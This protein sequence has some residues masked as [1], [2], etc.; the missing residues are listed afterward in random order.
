MVSKE[1]INGYKRK[2]IWQICGGLFLA[3][4]IPVSIGDLIDSINGVGENDV[5]TSAIVLAI[6]VC[7]PIMC[8][9]FAYK[10]KEKIDLAN[11]NQ[12]V[13]SNVKDE[14][15]GN[16]ITQNKY[17]DGFSLMMAEEKEKKEEKTENE[18]EE[19]LEKEEIDIFDI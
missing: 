11:S 17:E 1:K 8:F 3:L 13:S 7:L 5:V 2:M 15:D 19:Q 9:R 6:F 10:N 16:D 4:C 14:L 18:K 12:G